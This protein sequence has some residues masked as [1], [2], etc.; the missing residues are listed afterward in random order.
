MNMFYLNTFKKLL[1]NSSMPI[2]KPYG[3]FGESWF[4]YLA[5]FIVVFLSILAIT[6]VK[7]LN[8]KKL[9]ILLLTLA[10]VMLIF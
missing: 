7:K 5:L 9:S 2:P 1:F 6:K 10:L 4:H 8:Q 3:T